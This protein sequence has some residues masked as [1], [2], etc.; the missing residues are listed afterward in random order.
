MS[1]IT[2]DVEVPI[3]ILTRH[4]IFKDDHRSN[5]LLALSM[6]N[7]VALNSK[8]CGGKVKVLR[9][10]IHCLAPLSKIARTASLVKHQSLFRI[11]LHRLHKLRFVASLGNMNIDD[12]AA[13]AAKP[14][15]ECFSIIWHNA[16]KNFTG[17]R[18]RRGVDDIIDGD[19]LGLLKGTWPR[20]RVLR[21]FRVNLFE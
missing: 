17:N 13:F 8:R 19:C 15:S 20:A 18:T 14:L 1:V 21:Y 12:A 10:F 4:A 16:H 3:G 7:V 6:R 2:M 9:Q 5:L 11:L